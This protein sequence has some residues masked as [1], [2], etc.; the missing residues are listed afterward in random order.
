MN[1]QAPM[2]SI[3]VTLALDK[4]VNLAKKTPPKIYG[5]KQKTFILLIV[6]VA[7]LF[8]F[9]QTGVIDFSRTPLQKIFLPAQIALH[10]TRQDFQNFLGTVV[11][12][13]SLR[14]KETQTAYQ[15]ALLTAE[16]A[17]LRGLE[18]ENE[19]LRAQLGAAKTERKLI[20]AKVIGQDPLLSSSKMI[21]DKGK[22][23][24][25]KRGYLVIVKDILV[26]E[27]VSVGASSS[28]I[29]LL[30]D[31][32]TKI[33][34]I[35]EGKVKGILRGQF[36]NQI[37]LEKIVQAKKLKVGELVFSS[38]EEDMPKGLVLGKITKVD[39]E[40]AELFQKATIEPLV[41]FESLEIVFIVE[42]AV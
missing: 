27:V 34:A 18:E 20:V 7:A 42:G 26:G 40:P 6:A 36:G 14:E 38:G 16:N 23:D 1:K 9:E 11:S 19:A 5:A 32:E 8:F 30:S 12:I 39:N 17:R 31:S 37:I 21:I 24:L 22:N 2:F 28:T 13:K 15:N 33:P 10:K 29:R 25:V 35:T 4:E 3:G 41:S